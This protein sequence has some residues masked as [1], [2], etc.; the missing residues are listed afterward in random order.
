MSEMTEQLARQMV[1]TGQAGL[2]R[3]REDW[4]WFTQMRDLGAQWLMR[5][6][7]GDEAETSS[8][9]AGKPKISYPDAIRQI[10]KEANGHPLHRQEI[11]RRA[12]TLGVS[13][14]AK[15]IMPIVDTSL[16]RLRRRG[17]AENTGD[18]FWRLTT[19]AVGRFG[20]GSN[21]FSASPLKMAQE[22]FT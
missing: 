14:K 11:A 16:R 19:G 13:T 7:F 12:V 22:S 5:N 6:G 15:N 1:A 2:D 8:I 3:L 17:E 18:G 9:S 4:D 20:L 10:L 21:G